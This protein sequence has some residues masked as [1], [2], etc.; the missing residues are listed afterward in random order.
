V[1]INGAPAV[2]KTN[3][4]VKIY[5][6]GSIIMPYINGMKPL[7]VYTV[8]TSLASRRVWCGRRQSLLANAF[9]KP[10][11]QLC[12][13][14][15]LYGH[16]P[17]KSDGKGYSQVFIADKAD[18]QLN[19]PAILDKSVSS[20]RVLQWNDASKKGFAVATLTINTASEHLV[21]LQLGCGNR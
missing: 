17:T 8:S 19:L 6:N 20:F 5:A 12:A 18:L 14:A 1:R 13:Q 21:E 2:N 9:N 15:W 16:V 10:H 3:C 11:P 4:L 7:T